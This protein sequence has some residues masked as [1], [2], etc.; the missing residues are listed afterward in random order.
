MLSLETVNPLFLFLLQDWQ[1]RNANTVRTMTM[2]PP[3]MKPITIF[4][5]L[6][7]LSPL[8]LLALY[9]PNPL[10]PKL[11]GVSDAD[12]AGVEVMVPVPATPA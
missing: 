6:G 11:F 7:L 8:L 9:D 3:M 1:S 4:I 12:I 10:P 5:R 2:T